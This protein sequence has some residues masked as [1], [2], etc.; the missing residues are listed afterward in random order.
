MLYPKAKFSLK[1]IILTNKEAVK[2]VLYLSQARPDLIDNIV[3]KSFMECEK[4][5]TNNL[6]NFVTSSKNLSHATHLIIDLTGL[7]DNNDEI[8]SALNMLKRI[9]AEMRIIVIADSEKLM[10]DNK[11]LLRRI[12]NKGIYDI[13]TAVSDEE[14]H[15]SIMFGISENQAKKLFETQSEKEALQETPLSKKILSEEQVFIEEKS[16]TLIQPNKSFREYKKHLTIAVC[17]AQPHAGATHVAIQITKFLNDIG[18]K[19]AYLEAQEKRSILYLKSLYPQRC[20]ANERKSLLQCFGVP[21][22]SGFKISEVLSYDYDFFIFDLG[23]LTKDI[24]TSFLT[25]DIQILIG[26]SKAWELAEIAEA[27]KLI[28]ERNSI[29]IFLNHVIPNDK[30]RLFDFM[31]GLRSYTYFMEYSPNPFQSGVNLET[32]KK[33]FSKYLTTTEATPK[34]AP[35]KKG[36]FSTL[37]N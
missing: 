1:T 34:Q 31:E 26:G 2:I 24:L 32:Y 21:L 22:Y 30:N 10:A 8:I 35:T 16:E 37:F 12:F 19:A 33:V 3:N 20:N 18:F 14:I 9:Y 28:G 5:Q 29:N 13:I 11:D 4:V 27:V 6:S 25:K 17:S 36:L 7:V 15:N 23:T